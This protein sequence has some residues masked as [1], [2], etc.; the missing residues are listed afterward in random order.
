LPF[1]GIELYREGVYLQDAPR[2]HGRD[3]LERRLRLLHH[4]GAE[5]QG[6]AAEARNGHRSP[7]VR[8]PSHDTEEIPSAKEQE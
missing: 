5:W 1:A 7:L 3:K 2:L 6:L 8:L 4:D